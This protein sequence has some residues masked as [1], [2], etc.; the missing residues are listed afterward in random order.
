[1]GLKEIHHYDTYVPILSE[2][3]KA[4]HLGPSRRGGSG[5]IETA[6]Y[7]VLSTRST[8]DCGGVGLTDIPTA[9]SKAVRFSCGS[10]DGDPYI[11][12]NFKPEVL[13]DVFTLTHEAGSLDAQLV[14]VEEPAVSVLQLY[15]FC[16][17]SCQHVQRTIVDTI[18]CLKTRPMT[19]R[20]ARI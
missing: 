9:A 14:F 8:R 7:R 19:I 16:R 18:T 17:R 15:D 10:F 3:R 6:R 12:M 13:N 4:S 1:M 11:L 20:S 2:Y 5:I